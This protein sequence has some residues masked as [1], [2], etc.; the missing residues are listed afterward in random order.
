MALFDKDNAMDLNYVF[1][2]PASKIPL[3][4]YEAERYENAVIIQQL[5]GNLVVYSNKGRYEPVVAES[6]E[7]ED[8][9]VWR[10][11]LKPGFLCEDGEHITARGLKK[12]IELSIKYLAKESPVTI[13]SKLKGYS[14]FV[15]QTADDVSGIS[16]D[17]NAIRFSFLSP[18]RSGLVEVLSFAPFGYICTDNRNLDGT[19]RDENKFISSGPYQVT[20]HIPGIR[21][22]IKRR[23]DWPIWSATA[24]QSVRFTYAFE[25]LENLELPTV[26]DS[27]TVPKEV[28]QG[29][30]RYKLV[31]EYLNPII[32]YPNSTGEFFASIENRRA[33]KNAI[34]MARLSLPSEF[35]N[36]SKSEFF[37]ATQ[38]PKVLSLPKMSVKPPSYDLVIQG[39]EPKPGERKFIAWNILSKALDQLQWSFRFDNTVKSFADLNKDKSDIQLRAWSV[40]GGAE[41]WITDSIFYS[42]LGPMYPDPSKGILKILKSHEAGLMTDQHFADEFNQIVHD[43]AAIVAISHFGVLMY[44]S[45]HINLQ[46]VSPLIS[47]MRF[48]MLEL[49]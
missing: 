37:Y 5:V 34:E 8:E 28:P 2:N 43:D 29:L 32:M 9:R 16:T 7:M 49:E 46:S 27:F 24:P 38:S 23:P 22:T 6:W 35:D 17:G 41:A 1:G 45:K 40:G 47:V 18:V 13:L 14:E 25:N 26:L 30:K 39:K 48:N 20:E 11:D 44:F 15:S 42:E 3:N 12:S 4:L 36:H 31:P 21:H 10:F 19:W 33:L